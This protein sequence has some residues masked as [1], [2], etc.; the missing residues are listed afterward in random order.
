MADFASLWRKLLGKDSEPTVFYA[1]PMSSYPSEQDAQEA[2]KY[3]FGYGTPLE[4]YIQGKQARVVG[5]L[6]KKEFMPGNVSG[7]DIED[8]A[9]IARDETKSKNI[10]IDNPAYIPQARAMGTTLTQAAL[11]TNRMPLASL[12]FDPNIIAFDTMM[13]NPNISGAYSPTKD[14]IFSTLNDRDP[15]T[16]VHESIHRGINQLRSDPTLAPTF[17]NLP[18][19]EMLVRY[20]MAT[21]AGDPEK[22]YSTV[23]NKQREDALKL[24]K[25]T[26]FTDS[27]K[28]LEDAA[29]IRLLARQ[30]KM[31]PR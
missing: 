7:M 31:G 28:Q 18:S 17:K 4:P 12:G 15:S 30:P 14:S 11:A 9:G 3:G 23:G 25:R 6:G 5:Q 13:A 8:A 1:P 20:L 19:E 22:N 10:D 2:R 26:N 27:V 21:Q 29:K 16:P 24:F